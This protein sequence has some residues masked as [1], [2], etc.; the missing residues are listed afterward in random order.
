MWNTGGSCMVPSRRRACPFCF[1]PWKDVM[2]SLW[3]WLFASLTT[4]PLA[5]LAGDHLSSGEMED[6]VPC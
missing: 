4:S 2:A 6:P 5:D 1:L 3:G